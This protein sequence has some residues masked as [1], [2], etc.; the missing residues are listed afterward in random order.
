L[1]AYN[2]NPSSMK[3][4]LTGFF[5]WLASHKVSETD[6]LLILGDMNE[7]GKDGARYHKEVG[8][9]LKQWPQAHCV[10]IG[11]YASEYLSGRGSGT[12]YPEV[13]KFKGDEW[14]HLTNGKSYL[15]IK[16]SRSLQ[17]ESLIGIT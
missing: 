1:D 11:R 3:V 7:L 2:A 13:T 6:S 10:F 15:F 4:A 9:Y 17:L 16:G 5:E 14:N 8:E 12:C